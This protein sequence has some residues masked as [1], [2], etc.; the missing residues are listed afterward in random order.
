MSSNQLQLLRN[1][2][3]MKSSSS[4]TRRKF[5]KSAALASATPLILRSSIWAAPNAINSQ[6]TLG[7]IG[8]GTQGCG[9][10]GGFINRDD[11]RV[12]AVCDVDTHRRENAKSIVE[13]HYAS[14]S[15]AGTYKGCVSYNDFRELLARKDIDAVVIATPIIGMR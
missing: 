10:L 2:R 12:I 7:F 9:L 1:A 6:I 8:M 3:S 15:A 5:L 13:Q 11:T 4:I 14:A